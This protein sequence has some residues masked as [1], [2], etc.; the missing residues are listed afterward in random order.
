MNIIIKIMVSCCYLPYISFHEQSKRERH[1]EKTPFMKQGQRNFSFFFLLHL[2]RVFFFIS[3]LAGFLFLPLHSAKRAERSD[4][5]LS[6]FLGLLMLLSFLS[7][8]VL[9]LLFY[10]FIFFLFACSHTLLKNVLHLL[11]A[12]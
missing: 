2:V 5:Y 3:L 8:Y 1:R 7:L 4:R 6:V 9:L 10:K 12:A 11:P